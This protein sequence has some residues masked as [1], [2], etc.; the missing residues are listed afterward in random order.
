MS[1][2]YFKE[3]ELRCLKSTVAH[4]RKTI[5]EKESEV[6]EIGEMLEAIYNS[7]SE[8]IWVCD[9]AG[10]VLHV[11]KA[12]E[13]L[14]GVQVSDLVGMTIDSLVD[15]GL[16]D[17]S[18]TKQVL[19]TRQQVSII[20]N[21]PK[22]GKQL[23]VTGT[24]VFDENDS[25]SMV[26]VNE[27][28]LTQLNDLKEE[29]LEAKLESNRFKEELTHLSLADLESHDIIAQSQEMQNVLTTCHKLA[30][31]DVSSVLV[32]GESGT[33][34]GLIA[35]YMHQNNPRLTGPFVKINCAAVPENLLEAELFG[36]EKGAFTGAAEKGKIGLFEMAQGGTLFLD[37][38]GEL[39][40]QLQAKLLHCL[41]EREIMHLGALEP[42]SINCNV[43]AATNLNLAEN[44]A[45]GLF[46]KDLFYRLN[47]FPVTLPPLRNRPEDILGLSM[48]FLEKF[49][50]E[51]GLSRKIPVEEIRRLQN[52]HFPGNV[53]ELKNNFKR[54]MIMTDKD[55]LHWI[56]DYG[57]IVTVGQNGKDLS[58][59][60]QKYP[61]KVSEIGFNEIISSFEKKILTEALKE[62]NSTRS[63]A[64]YLD[65]TPS[66]AYRKLTKHNL[67]HLLKKRKKR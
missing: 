60:V 44:V 38:I 7:S 15:E 32:L 31:L 46:R 13:G 6:R 12:T 23:L 56:I 52:Y 55:D 17:Q 50:K 36:Y 47:T 3:Q 43:I 1:K 2:E 65:M 66:Q 45:N 8:S 10:T 67:T 25:I 49:N 24:P 20:Q 19:E 58:N 41:E 28:D 27:R 9:G 30:S 34:K 62:C 16:M 39:P 29:L 51:Y 59:I 48:Y 57:E 33:G 63:L 42:V 40:L 5:E 21:V 14:L 37:E 64:A 18:V 54:S 53:R 4:L 11:N 22:I 61:G 26:I 35:K